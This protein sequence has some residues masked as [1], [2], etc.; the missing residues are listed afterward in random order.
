M[1]FFKSHAGQNSD[2][3][4]L[5][6]VCWGAIEQ[7]PQT[8]LIENSGQG[9]SYRVLDFGSISKFPGCVLGT[10]FLLSQLLAINRQCPLADLVHDLQTKIR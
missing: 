5:H 3:S 6:T 10:A 9:L 8:K 2:Y 7:L 4:W 1:K